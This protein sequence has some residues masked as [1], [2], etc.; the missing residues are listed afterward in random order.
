VCDKTFNSVVLWTAHMTYHQ[1]QIDLN[2]L[3]IQFNLLESESNTHDTNNE[4]IIK[5]E[6]NVIQNSISIEENNI[7]SSTMS[8]NHKKK[9]NHHQL[10]K[11]ISV[12]Y[13]IGNL[14]SAV[15]LQII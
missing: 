15:I 4:N 6:L 11:R 14:Q 7:D 3:T 10:K 13:V 5:F 12:I 2:V 9:P 1:Q 8:R